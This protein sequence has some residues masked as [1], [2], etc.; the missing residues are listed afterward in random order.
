MFTNGMN[1]KYI[2]LAL[3]VPGTIMFIYATLYNIYNG[4]NIILIPILQMRKLRQRTVQ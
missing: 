3:T 4:L 2:Y 1:N